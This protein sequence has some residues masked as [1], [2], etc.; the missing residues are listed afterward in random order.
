MILDP[1]RA[2]ALAFV[3]RIN[4]HDLGGLSALMTEDHRFV[5]S[6]GTVVNGRDRVR[7]GWQ[8]YFGMVPD[9]HLRVEQVMVDGTTVVLLGRAEGTYAPDGHLR[10]SNRWSTP[11]ALVA[12]VRGAEL[13]EWRVYADNEPIRERMR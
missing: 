11:A 8:A 13:A 1:P 4:A 7:R 6:L 3:E 10:P 9:Y 12:R 5:D 2:V